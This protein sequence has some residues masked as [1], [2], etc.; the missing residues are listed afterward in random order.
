MIWD[1]KDQAWHD[2]EKKKFRKQDKDFMRC[3]Y[4]HKDDYA[5]FFDINKDTDKFE[6]KEWV[7]GNCAKKVNFE[8]LS[9]LTLDYIKN[10]YLMEVN[11]VYENPVK[12]II[13][14]K[15]GKEIDFKI[16]GPQVGLKSGTESINYIC[17]NCK[18][19]NQFTIV[20]KE[21]S[22]YQCKNCGNYNILD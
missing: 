8:D 2:S 3:P 12:M 20:N 1:K 19:K 10:I 21:K 11:I 13:K 17:G 9:E 4:C 7:C 18:N 5:F 6:L 16:L 15:K 14:T 22:V